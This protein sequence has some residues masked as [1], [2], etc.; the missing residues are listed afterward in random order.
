MR[1]FKIS[2]NITLLLGPVLWLLT[3][4]A[5]RLSPIATGQST[6]HYQQFLPLVSAPPPGRL[7]IAAAHID[8]AITGEPDEAVLIWNVGSGPQPLAGWQIATA[9]RSASFPITTTLR[10]EPGQRIWCTAEAAAFR[11][12]FGEA[13]A[14]EWAQSTEATTVQ[15]SNRLTFGNGQGQ[16]QLIDPTGQVVDTLLYG[17]TDQPA[18]GW[19]G[20]P[21]QAYNR[22]DLSAVGQVWQRKL[23]PLTWQPIDSDQATDWIGDLTDPAWGRRVRMPGW[24]G[25]SAAD[26]GMPTVATSEATV[27]VMVGPEGLY[28][29][30]QALLAEATISIDLVLYT[31]EH[32]ELAQTLAAAAQRGVQVRLLLEGSP[33]GGISALQKWALTQIVAAGGDVRFLAVAEDAPKG[34]RKRY[35][36]V[37]AKYLVIDNYWAVVG[38]ENWSHDAMPTAQ[39]RPVGGRRGYYVAT[40]APAVVA[41]LQ[42]IFAADW[43]PERFKDIRPYI[44][45]DPRY[46]GPPSDFVLPVPDEY[47]V[48]ESPFR[49]PQTVQD[50]MTF[51]LISAP[52]NAL[53]PDAGLLAVI[54]QAGAGDEIYLEQLYEHRHW[55]PT[56]SNPIADPNPRLQ[57]LIDAARRG[58]KVRL[59][60]DSF[61]DDR[62]SLR[63]NRATVDYLTTIASSEGLDLAAAVG[64]PTAGGIHAKVFLARVGGH[65]WSAIGSLNGSEISHKI[66]REVVLM[67]DHPQVYERLLEVFTHDWSLASSE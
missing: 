32:P 58:A 67:V 26:L 66:N 6:D 9:S 25:W 10:L 16:I 55:G 43:A 2:L 35:R 33:A 65:T 45:E 60:L 50:E 31:F 59:I 52:E 57:A 15:L 30:I 4:A 8:S 1:L 61:F 47:P 23:D 53:R 44:W 13:A 18:A 27:M 12:T 51:Q 21:A 24:G 49:L 56:A 40:D 36:Y 64:N 14:C 48:S 5:P 39:D 11:L 19:Q 29:P 54:Q 63:N 3:V 37:H 62:A 28:E 42:Q 46:G 41:G 34:Y 20:L 17:A 7:L 38:T 22:G